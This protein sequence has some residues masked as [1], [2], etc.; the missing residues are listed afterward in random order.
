MEWF[1]FLKNEFKKK[2]TGSSS[3]SME[4]KDQ[5]Y[6]KTIEDHSIIMLKEKEESDV[7]LR[8][9]IF[10]GDI[11]EGRRVDDSRIQ[12]LEEDNVFYCVLRCKIKED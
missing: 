7:Y 4:E 11:I 6:F 1:G 5:F 10:S 12:L 8:Y 2:N 9:R 3:K